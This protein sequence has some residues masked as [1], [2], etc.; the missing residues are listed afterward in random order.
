M[1]Q[2]WSERHDV[3]ASKTFMAWLGEAVGLVLPSAGL[4]VGCTGLPHVLPLQ[5]LEDLV[6]KA[7]TR[8][9]FLPCAA[10]ECQR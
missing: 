6:C 10:A 8:H 3:L 1:G 2:S 9:S 5:L 7:S 4:L